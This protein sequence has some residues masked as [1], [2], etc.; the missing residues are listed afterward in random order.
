MG[1]KHGAAAANCR[2]AS[3][4]PA[5]AFLWRAWTAFPASAAGERAIRTELLNSGY[6]PLDTFTP[7]PRFAIPLTMGDEAWVDSA[8]S[9]FRRQLEDIGIA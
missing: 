4:I 7:A 5:S 1:P 3:K 2:A 9:H 8:L 6:E